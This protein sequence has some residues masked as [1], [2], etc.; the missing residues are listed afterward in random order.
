[1]DVEL[2]FQHILFCKPYDFIRNFH[3]WCIRF[4]SQWNDVNVIMPGGFRETVGKTRLSRYT[5]RIK[6][7]RCMQRSVLWE[8]A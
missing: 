5:A 7:G 4:C 6:Q 3:K 1:M 2:S 8:N